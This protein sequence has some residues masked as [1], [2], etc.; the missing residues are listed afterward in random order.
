MKQKIYALDAFFVEKLKLS[1]NDPH[2]GIF[3]VYKYITIV[4]VSSEIVCSYVLENYIS[5]PRKFPL[6]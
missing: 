4:P 3:Q 1:E 5:L 6:I 2:I